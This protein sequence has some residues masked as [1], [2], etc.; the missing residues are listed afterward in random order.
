MS[1]KLL[2]YE[3]TC[4]EKLLSSEKHILLV[5]DETAENKHVFADVLSNKLKRSQGAFKNLNLSPLA[6]DL[7]NGG[8]ASVVVLA[9]NFLVL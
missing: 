9:A 6:M 7:P 8:V 2:Q 3:E 4:C 5:L 1:L